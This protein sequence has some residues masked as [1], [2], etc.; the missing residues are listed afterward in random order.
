LKIEFNYNGTVSAR[1]KE[2]ENDIERAFLKHIAEAGE[3]GRSITVKAL[4]GEDA[5]IE[6]SVGK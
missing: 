1:L 4:S 6:I 2:P 3:K 5:G